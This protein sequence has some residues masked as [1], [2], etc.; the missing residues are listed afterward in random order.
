MAVLGLVLAALAAFLAAQNLEWIARFAIHRVFPGVTAE[1]GSLRAVS[2]TRLEVRKFTLRATRTREPLL[3]LAG[4]SVTF[5]LGDV[6]RGRLDEVRLNAP[7]LVIS[8]D[9][10]EALGLGTRSGGG[11]SSGGAWAI[12][13]LVLD[14][15]HLRLTRFATD[16]PTLDLD[17]SADLTNFGVGSGAADVVHAVRL[18]NLRATDRAG[19]VVA[20]IDHADLQFTTGELFGRNHL[21]AARVGRGRLTVVPAL[22]SL[23]PAAAPGSASAPAT[24]GASI[25]SLDLDGLGVVI[26]DA[27]GPIGRVEFFV[28]AS[29][30]E[31]GAA[32]AIATQ[33]VRVENLRVATDAAPG[34]PFITAGAASARFTLTGLASRRL[35][36]LE[37]ENPTI[38]LA[39]DPAPAPAN[40]SS[41]S[42]PSAD[43]TVPFVI[44][45]LVTKFG[46]L[47]V[48]GLGGGAVDVSTQFSFDLRNLAT[49][50]EA[51]GTLHEL[52]VWDVRAEG[53]DGAPLLTLDV[54]TVG[55]RVADVL[56]RRHIESLAVKGGRLVVGGTLQKLLAPA[57]TATSTAPAPAAPPPENNGWSIGTVDIAGVRTRIEDNRPGITE[58]RFTLG[59]TLRNV[60]ARS[61]A[62][63]LLGEVQTVELA[64]I[65]LRSPLNPAAKILALRSVFVRFT[66]RDLARKHLREVVILRPSIYLSQDLFVYMER[67]AA[68][69]PAAPAPDP[70]AAGAEKNWSVEQLEV[71]FGRLVIGSGGS[72]DVGLPLE[73][74][75]S[76]SNLALDNLA[77]LQL[78][79]ALRVPRQDYEFPDYQIEVDNVEGDLRFAYPP[80]KGEKNLVQKLEMTG[81]RWRQYRAKDAWVAVT[82]DAR[83]IN[84][85]FG[86][87]AYRGYV[88]GG[89]SFFFQDDSP[90][91]GWVAGTGVDMEAVT[92]VISPQNF[93]M[94]GPADFE[95]QLDAFR[96]NIGRMRG[97]FQLQKPGRLRIGKLDD[98]LADLPPEWPMLKRS[99]TRIALET[100]RD[101]DY[102][103]AKGE[104]WFVQSQGLLNL[105]LR[106][107]N[108]SRAFE[109]ALHD[110]TETPN[111]WKQGKLGKK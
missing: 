36:R 71:K 90:W 24:P 87:A 69:D 47:R 86:G 2:P 17:V 14:R 67:A 23:A 106:G 58:L 81:V 101:F 55:F 15:G 8:P 19:A 107:P 96:K 84:G 43:L 42:V 22:F 75:T 104:F 34:S 59:T 30:R 65:S 33:T 3:T 109:I 45:E 54:G 78:T 46:S 70:A 64:N 100:L 102:T 20:E 61:L 28:T 82:F 80:D 95:I 73:F 63:E 9:L 85:Q 38:D 76:A 13:R 57:P 49:S 10:G 26:P 97:V 72:D 66:L 52:T 41:G 110:G 93:R 11:K 48:Q 79:A 35:D 32:P 29:L 4:G 108:G 83:G 31:V 18:T 16:A 91:I 51:A 89:F 6:W 7:N 68:A 92:D 60:S 111:L 1:M 99:T 98:L 44:G 12:G 88:N 27:P 94:T 74:E 37:I 105:D 50:G 21:R 39:A 103:E 62:N 40:V 25:G 77:A 53:A 5:R 56:A